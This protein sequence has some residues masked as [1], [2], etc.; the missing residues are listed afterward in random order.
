[1]A[2]VKKMGNRLS[3]ETGSINMITSEVSHLV[4]TSKINETASWCYRVMKMHGLSKH[5]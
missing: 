2:Q 3:K 1:M 5:T 4:I